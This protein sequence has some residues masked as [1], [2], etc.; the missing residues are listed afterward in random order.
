MS[1]TTERHEDVKAE[2]LRNPKVR[3]AYDAL[4]PAH[5]I[6]RLR[7]LR[8]LTQEE[9][10]QMVGTKQPSIARLESG[11]GQASIAFMRRVVEALGG[12]LTINIEA[13]VR[14]PHA[15]DQAAHE[16]QE[17]MAGQA[18]HVTT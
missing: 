17:S 8:G 5:Q 18:E 12:V 16:A 2:I 11:H 15:Q 14:D 6:T 4:Q 7:L 10:A 13:P 3:A 1:D 9:V